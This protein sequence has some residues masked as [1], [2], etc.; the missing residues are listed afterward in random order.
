VIVYERAIR[1]VDVVVWGGVPGRRGDGRDEG[2]LREKWGIVGGEGE[3]GAGAMGIDCSEDQALIEGQGGTTLVEFMHSELLS[4]FSNIVPQ[5][6]LSSLSLPFPRGTPTVGWNTNRAG[7]KVRKK[8]SARNG[9]GATD[10]LSWPSSAHP[11]LSS[12]CLRHPAT[13]VVQR[14]RRAPF[15]GT[16]V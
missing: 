9:I 2:H 12:S 10:L 7:E 14:R 16:G 11:C 6:P 13:S 8:P 5:K 1:C 3:G 4:K 15:Q